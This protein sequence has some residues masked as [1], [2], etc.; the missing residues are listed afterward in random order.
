MSGGERAERCR[1]QIQRGEG[2]AAVEKIEDKR[3]PED[4]FGNRNRMPQPTWLFRRKKRRTSM[5]GV[6]RFNEERYFF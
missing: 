6:R 4:F 5:T 2:V 3:E 1:W